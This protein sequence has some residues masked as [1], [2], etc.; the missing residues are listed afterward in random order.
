MLVIEHAESGWT[1]SEVAQRYLKWLHKWNGGAHKYVLW[2]LYSSHRAEETK[3]Y[4]IT[5]EITLQYIPN[6]QIGIWQPLDYRIFGELKSHAKARFDALYGKA[7]INS[8]DPHVDM[9]TVLVI[10]GQVWPWMRR[11]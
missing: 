7:L 8:E 6:G 4:A 11:M 1:S 10:L 3:E 9:N 2:D 5:K